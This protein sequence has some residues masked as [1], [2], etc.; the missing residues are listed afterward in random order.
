M[1]AVKK[2]KYLSE[3]RRPGAEAGWHFL[4]GDAAS[5]AALIERFAAGEALESEALSSDRYR[6]LTDAVNKTGG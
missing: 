2:A 3:Y 1:K 4:T 5:I 6:Q